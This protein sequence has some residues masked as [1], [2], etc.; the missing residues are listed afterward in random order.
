MKRGRSEDGEPANGTHSADG[1][2]RSRSE[3]PAAGSGA[4]ATKSNRIAALK[5]KIA[6]EKKKMEEKK[7][8]LQ[9]EARPGS[10][11]PA[12]SSAGILALIDL[13]SSSHFRFSF[14]SSRAGSERNF[15]TAQTGD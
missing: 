9:S 7:K 3:A 14:R 12:F 4:A 11:R 5:A 15:A 6:A 13:S 10:A 2:K 1:T 8:T